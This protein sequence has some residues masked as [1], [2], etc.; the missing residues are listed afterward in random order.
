MPKHG[1]FSGPFFPV[2]GPGKTQKI[3]TFHAAYIFVFNPRYFAQTQCFQKSHWFPGT[4]RIDGSMKMVFM[5][6]LSDL[7]CK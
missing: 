5:F 7:A 3:D 6:N 4:F 1:V 2:F